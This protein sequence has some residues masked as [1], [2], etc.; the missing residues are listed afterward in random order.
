MKRKIKTASITVTT[1]T[2]FLFL[3]ASC[4]KP[5]ELTEKK[6]PIRQEPAPSPQP[7]PKAPAPLT[8]APV[9]GSIES[10]GNLDELITIVEGTPGKLL[11][12]YLYAD[13]CTPC[14]MLAP[15]FTALAGAH[16]KNARFFRIDVQRNPD[17]AS[18]FRVNNIPLVV[19]MKDK[20]M[21]HALTGLNPRKNYERVIT[22][23]GPSVPAAE[24]RTKLS[25]TL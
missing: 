8:S 2:L 5:K 1:L 21:V 4:V 20:E 18:A 14:K 19:F 10:I 11:V 22:V 24:C 7:Q 25:G 13:W 15:T 12:F 17:I 6:D 9:K 3:A 23:C 16:S